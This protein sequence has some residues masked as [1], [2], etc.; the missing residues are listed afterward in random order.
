MVTGTV[1]A[2]PKIP[3]N[4]TTPIAWRK[5]INVEVLLPGPL[6]NIVYDTACRESKQAPTLSQKVS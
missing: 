3:P 4:N 5:V 2:A 6:L 1:I